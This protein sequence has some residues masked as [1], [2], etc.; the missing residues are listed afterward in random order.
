MKVDD[1]DSHASLANFSCVYLAYCQCT[2]RGSTEKMT[3]AAAFT[4]GDSDQ[5]MVGRNGVFYDRKGQDWDA[6]IVRILE[7]PISIKQA[8]WSPYKQAGRLI[9]EQLMK[10]A[11]ARSRASSERLAQKALETGVQA[12]TGK[13]PAQEK[14]FDAGKFAGIFAAIGLAIG[15]IGSAITSMV[16]GLFKLPLW[17]WPLLFIGMMLV[18]SGPSVFIAWFKLRKRNLWPILDAN[19]WAVNTRAKINIKFGT[20]LTGLAKLPEGSDRSLKDPYAEERSPWGLYL[21][22]IILI[23]AIIILWKMGYLFR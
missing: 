21:L 23:V 9:S 14:T 5:L 20:L 8:F 7:H 10:I 11:A 1:I 13:P 12:G 15:F 6:T 19:G 2:R 4:A 3:I 16:T 17:K 18:I 22:I